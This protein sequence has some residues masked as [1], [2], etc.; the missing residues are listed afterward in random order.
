MEKLEQGEPRPLYYKVAYAILY[1]PIQI[2]VFIWNWKEFIRNVGL[3]KRS[4][5]MKNNPVE[6]NLPE[7]P[8]ELA[9]DEEIEA[10]FAAKRKAEEQWLKENRVKMFFY[11]FL[12]MF[13]LPPV[14]AYNWLKRRKEARKGE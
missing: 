9:S 7:L 12:S 5:E 1:V 6:L 11:G 8:D 2:A 4:I 14:I 10:Y 13:F 3:E